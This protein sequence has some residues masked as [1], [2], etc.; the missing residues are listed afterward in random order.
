MN[1]VVLYIL[2]VMKIRAVVIREP[3]SRNEGKPFVYQP[4]M[5]KRFC[6]LLP[7]RGRRA[8]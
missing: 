3:V 5:K 6:S 1:Q 7:V 2:Y 8:M 4:S